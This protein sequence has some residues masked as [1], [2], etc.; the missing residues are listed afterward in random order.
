MDLNCW[1]VKFLLQDS[2]VEEFIFFLLKYKFCSI[3]ISYLF[4]FT[5]TLE[6]ICSVIDSRTLENLKIPIF[7]SIFFPLVNKIYPYKSYLVKKVVCSCFKIIKGRSYFAYPC[8]NERLSDHF[9][10][11]SYL[12]WAYNIITILLTWSIM[13]QSVLLSLGYIIY[14]TLLL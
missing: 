8:L 6:L 13:F 12:V 9:F 14:L 4:K 2:S 11:W 10:L 5:D 3:E 7:M 1:R